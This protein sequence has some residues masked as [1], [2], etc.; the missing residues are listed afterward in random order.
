MTKKGN[1]QT[2]TIVILALA[3]LVMSI[4]FALSDVDLTMTGNTEVKSASWDIHFKEDSFNESVGSVTATNPVIDATT[5]TY[6]VTLEKPGDFYEFEIDV[7]NG[8]TF[9]AVLKSITLSELDA[10]QKKYLTYKVKYNGTDYTTT[11][12]LDSNTNTLTKNGGT[13]KFT[14]RVDYI[15]PASEVDLPATDVNLTLT[16]TLLYVQKV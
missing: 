13:E 15:Q 16:T 1:Y 2:I 12:N 10:A 14:V 3:I 4:G 5:V 11:T 9:D 7:E 6:S 8:G